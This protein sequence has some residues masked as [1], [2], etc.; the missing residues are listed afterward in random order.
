[1][2]KDSLL[3][4]KSS[5]KRLFLPSLVISYFAAS[6]LSILTSLFLIDMAL[7]FECS[8]GVIGQTNTLSSIVAVIFALIMGA[9]SVR[10]RHKSLLMIG[11]LSIFIS[12]L[13]CFLS[14]DLNSAF[15]S[16]SLS[17][18]GWA[19]VVPMT[20]T[21]VG[22]YLPL[23][24]RASAVGWVV[25][26]GSLAYFIGAPV[27]ALIAGLG[28]WRLTLLGFV[29]P[30]SFASLLLAFI[31]VP[32][33]S[34]IH[35]QSMSKKTILESFKEVFSNK[36][37][38]AC[39]VGNVLRSA[40]FMA[41]LLYAISFFRERLLVSMEFASIILLVA[42]LCYTLGSLASGRFVNRFGRKTVTV[43]TALLSGVFTISFAYAPNLWISLA[44]SF[45]G[46]WFFGMVTSS[47]SSLTL[48]QVPKFR[49]TMMSVNTAA[50]NLG[51]A[52][53]AAVGGW[54]LILFSYEALGSI[55]GVMGIIAAIVFYLLTADPTRT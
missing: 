4:E 51:S 15:I 50:L 7:T 14:P 19:M 13:G 42:A 12:A 41:I 8:E 44:L 39:L 40:A 29:M 21:L 28:G 23:E 18:V 2:S 43:L 37:A 1:M 26:G 53:G 36:S 55:L 10:F 20:V 24:R 30:I 6:P 49:G 52:L 46:C 35:Q 48:E 34:S 16:Y 17:G 5:P 38:M 11:I 27:M 25:A 9:L 3:A 45:I 33:T 32:S 47:A 54:A 22:E 31:G